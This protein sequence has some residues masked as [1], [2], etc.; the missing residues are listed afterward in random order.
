MTLTSALS[1]TS[2]TVLAGSIGTFSGAYNITT[3]T[4]NIYSTSSNAS[5]ILVAAQTLSITTAI[6]AD[7]LFNVPS[8]A[9]TVTIKSATSSSSTFINYTGAAN[10][11]NIVGVIFTDINASGSNQALFNYFGN[12]LTRTV[13]IIN[14]TSSNIGGGFFIQ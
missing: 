8:V 2:L 11:K 13:N 12:T 5:L 4:L 10:K 7:S 6:N 3:G 9:S 14:V 1:T